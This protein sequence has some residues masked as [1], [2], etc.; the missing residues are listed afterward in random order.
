MNKKRFDREK[1]AKE[2]FL[3]YEDISKIP[4]YEE[5]LTLYML[6][7]GIK[8]AIERKIGDY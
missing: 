2:K 6:K 1:L 8:S 7:L 3:P 5:K 4:T